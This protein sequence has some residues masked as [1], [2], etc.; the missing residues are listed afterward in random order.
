MTLRNI[1]QGILVLGMVLVG[2]H[3]TLAI[4]GDDATI[5][6]YIR[7]RWPTSVRLSDNG[8]LYFV[9]NPDGIRQLYAV[10]P[11]QKQEDAVRLT[12][13]PDGI[14]GY[15]L[16]EDGR[17]ITVSAGK[18]G[19]EQNDLYMI[20]VGKNRVDPLRVDPD[21]VFGSVLWRRDSQVLAYRAND[22]SPSDFHV[23]VYN[24]ASRKHK[25]V[26]GGKGYHYPADFSRDNRRL[27]VAKY[28]S[29]SYSQ[30]FEV[31]T[32]TLEVREITPTDG[33][34]SFDP[35]GYTSGDRKFLVNTNYEG[36]SK[37]VHAINLATGT[38]TPVLPDLKGQEVDFAT[39]DSARLFLAVLVNEGGYRTVHI[40]D[41]RTFK[42]M[43][44]PN[45]PKGIVGNV[46]LKG[47]YMLYSLS[48]AKTPGAVYLWNV[49]S[50]YKDGI[51]LT[52]ADTQGIDVSK[53]RLPEL[54]KYPSFDGTKIPA[55]VYL[56]SDYKAGK[57]IPFIVYYHGG[58]E[59]QFRPGFNRSFQYFVSRGYGVIAPNVRGS[60]GYGKKYLEADNYKNRYKSVRDG[61]WAA[62]YVVDKGYA[63]ARNIAAWGGSYGGFMTMAVI[64]E[65]PEWFGAACNVVGI[66][67]FETFLQKTKAYRRHLREAEYGPLSDPEFLK[68]ISPLYK[69]DKITTP[70]LVAHGVNDPRVPVDEARQITAAL[71]KRGI[72][73]EELYFE[74]EGHGF[75]KENNRLRYYD[76][77]AKFFDKHLKH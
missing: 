63:K 74:D 48:N 28:N 46:I 55:F 67:N 14:S 47:Q 15:S 33:Q 77:L 41:G 40:R 21:V 73:V 13:F 26:M 45:L 32:S 51:P 38:I 19:N 1:R 25:K 72:D 64:T 36:D 4:E 2:S 8:A 23:Y 34:W 43:P 60:S 11:G 58:P 29:A 71:K 17:Y 70:L 49:N 10:A 9:H 66:V 76:T 16:S 35:I 52:S 65:A 6:N 27:V 3:P 20:K 75:A 5:A 56:P 37:T 53:F 39:M 44:S 12:D 61:I 54:I 22:T 30:L 69:V 59:G 31:D 62:K 57:T 50:P 24:L 18:G 68:S 42:A 7:M